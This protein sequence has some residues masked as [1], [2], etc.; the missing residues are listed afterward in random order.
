MLEHW[1]SWPQGKTG[2]WVSLPCHWLSR[3][4]NPLKMPSSSIQGLKVG[5]VMQ[6]KN[7]MGTMGSEHIT[8]Y[9]QNQAGMWKYHK[10]IHYSTIATVSAILQTH[11]SLKRGPLNLNPFFHLTSRQFR[12]NQNPTSNR[13]GAIYICHAINNL[14]IIC[15]HSIYLSRLINQQSGVVFTNRILLRFGPLPSFSQQPCRTNGA[16]SWQ[17]SSSRAS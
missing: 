7:A 14:R 8:S 1:G 17:G 12:R 15:H 4:S 16:L 5:D 10:N 3:D 6:L 9:E 2:M 13:Y 11:F